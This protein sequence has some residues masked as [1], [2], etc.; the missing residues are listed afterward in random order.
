MLSGPLDT[1][2]AWLKK[3]PLTPIDRFFGFTHT[4]DGQHPGHL[5]AFESLGLVGKDISVDGATPP[6]GDSQR[7]KT[8][9][10]TADG[11]SSVQAGGASPKMGTE[12]VFKPVWDY[13][14]TSA[15]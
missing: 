7:L 4:A 12:Y 9:A 11:H 3:T 5:A 10:P 14:Y 6:Y 1:N 2:Q 15:L 13:L 8:S